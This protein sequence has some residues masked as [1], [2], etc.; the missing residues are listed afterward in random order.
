MLIDL[1]GMTLPHLWLEIKERDELLA[2]GIHLDHSPSKLKGIFNIII[3]G[4]ILIY[5]G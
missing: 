4:S 5:L 2:K 1:Y 3:S